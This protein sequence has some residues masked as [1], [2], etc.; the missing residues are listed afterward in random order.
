M[1]KRKTSP[2][3]L[4]KGAV[5]GAT[6]YG[7][8]QAAVHWFDSKHPGQVAAEFEQVSLRDFVQNALAELGM[9]KGDAQATAASVAKEEAEK[10]ETDPYDD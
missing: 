4:A 5:S 8:G 6:A 10:E 9:K 7:I 2:K 1:A 3:T